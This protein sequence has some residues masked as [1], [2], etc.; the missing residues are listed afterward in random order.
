MKTLLSLLV[1]CILLPEFA[2]S[3]ISVTN[4]EDNST[5][6][7]PVILLRGEV[8]KDCGE[9]GIKI[10][11]TTSRVVRYQ[12]RFKSLV[13]LTEGENL[14]QLHSKNPKHDLELRVTYSP[15]T[16]PHYVRLIW[17]T[18]STGK[19]DYATLNLDDA[20]DFESR[21]QTAANLMQTFTAEKMHDIG[22]P[23]KTFRLER[24]DEGNPI[25]HVFKGDREADYYYSIKDRQWWQEIYQWV[26]REHPDPMAKNMVL[27]AYTRKDPDT[28]ELQAHTALGGGNLGLFGSA[29]VFSWPKNLDEAID[30]FQDDSTFD[31]S[32]VNNDSAGRDTI[33]GLASTTIGASLH[34]MGHTFD[35]P[36]CTDGRG[37]MTRGFDQFNRA[38]TFADPPSGHNRKTRHFGLE[39]EAYFSPVSATYLQLSPWFQLD[40]REQ[41]GDSPRIK[42][43]NNGDAIIT[44]KDGIAWLGFYVDSD[45][46]AFNEYLSAEEKP[47]ELKLTQA[48]MS[49]LL[50]G[51]SV[52][53]IRAVSSTG[54]MNKRSRP[55]R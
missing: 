7:Y 4:H 25:V 32:V 52:S 1:V 2:L 22:L 41:T 11:E 39:R 27:A 17:M 14:I 26:N 23:R 47:T 18:D 16:N 19:T 49:D 8:P 24:D 35:L 45:V 5:V 36:H 54:R 55:K 43:E 51:K 13:Q 28:G 44:C 31:S 40:P 15:Q 42:F 9:L 30:T 33:W 50:N 3:Q 37:I 53:S 48:E 12:D 38:F 6:R 46:H 10:G 29:S 21:M 34:E 20:Q